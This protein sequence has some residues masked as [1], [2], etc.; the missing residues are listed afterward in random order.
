MLSSQSGGVN[1]DRAQQYVNIVIANY[2]T[3]GTEPGLIV[4]G[5]VQDLPS[6]GFAWRPDMWYDFWTP[7]NPSQ[8]NYYQRLIVHALYV[9]GND[10]PG[11]FNTVDDIEPLINQ[12][13][14]DNGFA[15]LPY[16]YFRCSTAPHEAGHLFNLMHTWGPI[17]EK[18][19]RD[20][21]AFSNCD[22]DHRMS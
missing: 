3:E 13:Y 4:G 12:R 20:D 7:E 10:R 21:P 19:W 15:W 16:A 8:F 1:A 5:N 11:D 18:E 17:Q 22:S 14:R 9:G 2:S 6:L